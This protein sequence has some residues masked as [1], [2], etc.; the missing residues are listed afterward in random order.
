MVGY[1]PKAIPSVHPTTMVSAVEEHLGNLEKV[2]FEA[3]AAHELAR[4][5]MAE[6]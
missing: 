3:M 1:N 2:R 4:Q 6:H 5:H